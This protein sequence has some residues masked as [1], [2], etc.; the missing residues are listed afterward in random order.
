MHR[1][2]YYIAIIVSLVLLITYLHYT[3]HLEVHDLHNI[4]TELYYIP[5]LMAALVFRLKGAV[6]IYLLIVAL[7][8]PFVLM[9]W[10]SSYSYAVNKILHVVLL[11]VFGTL[12]GILLSREKKYL[13]QIEKERYLSGLGK[14]STTIV[15]ELKSPLVTILGFSRRIREGKGNIVTA[16]QAITE[17]AQ[18]MQ[19]I[20][21][22]V[23]NFAKPVRL[24][25]GEE[26]IR[27]VIIRA[28][29]S[30]KEKA[31]ME[32]IILTTKL[33]ADPSIAAI[34]TF[35]M[36]RALVNCHKQRY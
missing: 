28:R 2:H 35:H 12:A 16:S 19:M 18:K 8:L 25:F 17:A 11:G 13:K 29:D 30:C 31:D 23:L 14:V 22:D 10:N 7:Y 32:G 4:F 26:D 27:K 34:D 9:S 24:K 1:K 36:E 33:P 20:V 3:T 5:L 6:L 15:H 21:H